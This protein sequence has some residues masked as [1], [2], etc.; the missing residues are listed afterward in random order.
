MRISLAVFTVAM[1]M[2]ASCVVTS[3]EDAVLP[4]SLDQSAGYAE[5]WEQQFLF[6]GDR[7]LVSQF[8]VL[9]LP[10]SRHH[11]LMIGSYRDRDRLVIVKNGRQRDGWQYSPA[12]KRLTIF[13]HTLE[14]A[15]PGYLMRLHNTAAEFDVLYNASDRAIAITTPGN[16]LGLPTVTQYAPTA[17]AVGRWRPG[18]EIGGAGATER[19]QAL[20]DG[21]GYGLH[22]VQTAPLEKSLRRWRRAVALTGNSGHTPILHLMET[23]SSA[24]HVSLT[25]LTRFGPP[26]QFQKA[27]VSAQE[28]GWRIAADAGERRLSG[29]IMPLRDIETFVL[30]DHLNGIEVLAAR[31]LATIRRK[32]MTG[33]YAFTLKTPA[34]TSEISGAVL[35]EDIQIAPPDDRRRRLRRSR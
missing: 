31:A 6:K 12:D 27:I 26:I 9:N 13:Q 22:V 7:L 5:Y 30:K 19:W 10:L 14:G 2:Q 1:F 16:P 33:R 24:K 23:P 3:A 8:M 17:Q 11:G 18:P 21:R 32:R 35:M 34:G 20:G 15:Y 28:A 25:L 29:T 4:P